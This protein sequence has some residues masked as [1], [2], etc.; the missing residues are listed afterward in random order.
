MLGE[1][2][3]G[4]Q[5]FNVKRKLRVQKMCVQKNLRQN[6][7]VQKSFGLKKMWSQ[8]NCC[9]KNFI[10]PQNCGSKKILG[11]KYIWSKIILIQKCFGLKKFKIQRNGSPRKFLVQKFRVQQTLGS[12]KN[13]CPKKL[14]SNNFLGLYFLVQK[15]K[16][17]GL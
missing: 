10:V 12:R 9:P 6:K 3:S 15:V 13:L 2:F 11:P 8:K 4:S 17:L 14:L 5:I 16:H 1:K 7:C